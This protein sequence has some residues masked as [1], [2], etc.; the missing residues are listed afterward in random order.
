M[1]LREKVVLVLGT[2]TALSRPTPLSVGLQL[3]CQAGTL[4]RR[5]KLRLTR[6]HPARPPATAPPTWKKESVERAGR[7]SRP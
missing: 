1:L 3:E 2:M 4:Q 6:Y 7:L 5:T